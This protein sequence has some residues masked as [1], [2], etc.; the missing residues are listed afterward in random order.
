MVQVDI[1]TVPI[2]LGSSTLFNQAVIRTE[3]CF[4]PNHELIQ[5]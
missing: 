1:S 5:R 2:G 4:R 3:E